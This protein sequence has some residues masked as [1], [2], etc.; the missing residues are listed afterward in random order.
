MDGCFHHYVIRL[1]YS[2]W[3]F[4][5][6]KFIEIGTDLPLDLLWICIQTKSLAINIIAV[7]ASSERLSRF[8]FI[9][10]MNE[11]QQILVVITHFCTI[12]SIYDEMI[13]RESYL[14]TFNSV[15]IIAY[16]NT[17]HWFNA[18]STR[19]SVYGTHF[20]SWS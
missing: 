9:I 19:H 4:Q 14:S 20:R 1:K 16:I 15:W 13:H 7:H 17:V 12:D 3:S 5:N 10:I 8:N 6:L 11:R 2:G 18:H